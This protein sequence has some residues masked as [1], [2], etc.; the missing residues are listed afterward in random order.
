MPRGLYHKYDVTYAETGEE[1]E[2]E[3]FVL[4]LDRDPHAREAAR[5]Y[6]RSCREENRPLADA[7]ERWVRNCEKV[8]QSAEEE[9]LKAIR[10]RNEA[11]IKHLESAS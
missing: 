7:L 2:G 1:L 10:E 6:A 4:R 8:Q 3:I 9:L 11:V 5:A